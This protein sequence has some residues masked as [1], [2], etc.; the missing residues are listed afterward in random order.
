[1]SSLIELNDISYGYRS[2]Q[3]VL[4]RVSLTLD[5][6]ERLFITGPNGAGKSTLLRILVGLIKPH[7]GRISAFGQPRVQ[8]ADF[9]DLR[10]RVGFIVQD[11]DDQLFCPTV[12][13]D[14][15]FGPL[16]L[17]ASR[18]EALAIVDEVL[19]QLHLRHLRERIT[20]ELSGGEKRLVSVAAVLAMRPDVLLLDEPTNALDEENL[21]RLEEILRDLPQAMILI[22]HD[23]HFRRKLATRTL[24]LRG[25]KLSDRSAP[26]C[27]AAD[28]GRDAVNANANAS[29]SA[30]Q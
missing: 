28:R 17:G 7:H 12:V 10:C 14:I 15:A 1:M 23:P 2:G 4:D 11:P 24:E 22:S 8:E 30:A 3:K 25:G 20:H 29:A 27:S 16:N 26:K 21:E 13:E 19:D 9:H 5:A 18:D 6:G